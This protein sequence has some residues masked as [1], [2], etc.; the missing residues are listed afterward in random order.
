MANLLPPASSKQGKPE[1][2]VRWQRRKTEERE[3][4]R[5]EGEE[6]QEC[7]KFHKQFWLPRMGSGG[8]F[9]GSVTG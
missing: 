1:L 4:E 3:T 6:A 2:E 7:Q 5:L 8:A 9:S